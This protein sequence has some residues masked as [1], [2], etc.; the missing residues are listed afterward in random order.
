RNPAGHVKG[1]SLHPS[2]AVVDCH[3][4]VPIQSQYLSNQGNDHH[5]TDGP[6]GMI[7][8]FCQ[9]FRSSPALVWIEPLFIVHQSPPFFN[10]SPPDSRLVHTFPVSFAGPEFFPPPLTLILCKFPAI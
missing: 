7:V 5:D 3:E 6:S 2:S 1:L 8:F 4:M 9:T 10:H